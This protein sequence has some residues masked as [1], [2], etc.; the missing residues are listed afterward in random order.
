[1]SVTTPFFL[2]IFVA[3]GDPDGLRL[4]GRSNWIGKAVVFPRTLLP[5]IKKRD[6][7]NQTGVYLLL[8]PREDGEGE[9]LYIGQGDP[10]RDRL[11]AHYGKKD[12]WTKAVFFVDGA[13]QLNSAHMLF[14]ESHLI[15]LAKSARRITLDNGKNETE[16]TISEAARRH[17]GL[18]RQHARHTASAGDSRLR[19]GVV[20]HS[21]KE[22]AADLQGEERFSHR[23]RSDPGVRGQSRFK[24]GW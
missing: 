20:C 22:C 18:S 6:E 12:F 8:G 10:V 23:L 13:G 2:R 4:V 21:Q 1:M 16:P 15:Q 24:C 9:K 7:F 11:E 5:S 3:D 14:L 17:A 19:A